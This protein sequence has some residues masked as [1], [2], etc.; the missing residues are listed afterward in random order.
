MPSSLPDVAVVIPLHNGAPWIE[1][2]LA[3]VRAQTHRPAEIVVVDDQST[4]DGPARAAAVPGVT[5]RSLPQP[6]P[7]QGAGPGRQYGFEN[8]T[9]PFVAFLDQDDLWHP[10]HLRLLTTALRDRP[11]CPAAAGGIQTFEHELPSSFGASDLDLHPYDPWDDFPLTTIWTPSGVL[12]RRSAL[13]AIGGWPT[14]GPVTDQR[15]WFELSLAHP[16]IKNHC[17]TCGKREHDASK[18]ESLRTT[19]PTTFIQ[20]QARYLVPIWFQRT[21]RRPHEAAQL[22]LRLCAFSATGLL[23]TAHHTQSPHLL[24]DAAP[25]LEALAHSNR[26]VLNRLLDH[27]FSYFLRPTFRG[28]VVEQADL[29]DLFVAAWPDAAPRS[30]AALKTFLVRGL[31][32]RAFPLHVTRAPWQWDRWR[33]GHAAVYRW[34]SQRSAPLRRRLL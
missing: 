32:A 25:V 9:A 30:G 22:A 8:T 31:S 2:T 16:F 11:S 20:E 13:Q 14:D 21:R 19:R 24:R 29:L 33:L 17:V 27:L 18:S 28:G 23:A 1:E 15:A 26:R 3:S 5:V 12:V 7:V 10:E 4:D 34:L 6:T